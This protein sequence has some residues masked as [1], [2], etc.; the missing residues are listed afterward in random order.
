M[1]NLQFFYLIKFFLLIFLSEKTHKTIATM[2]DDRKIAIKIAKWLIAC[3][4]PQFVF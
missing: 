1:L 2:D 3:S 4:Q